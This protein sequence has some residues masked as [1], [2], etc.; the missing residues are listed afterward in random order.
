MGASPEGFGLYTKYGF[1]VVKYAKIEL[2]EYGDG[3]IK[4]IMEHRI[5]YRRARELEAQSDHH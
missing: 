4:G 3:E 2:G 5:M 1:V